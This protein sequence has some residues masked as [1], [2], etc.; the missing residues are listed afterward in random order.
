MREIVKSFRV[1]R[2]IMKFLGQKRNF[3]INV[4][5]TEKLCPEEQIKETYFSKE[6]SFLFFQDSQSVFSIPAETLAKVVETVT[7]VA[8][9]DFE[10]KIFETLH[11]ISTLAKVSKLFLLCAK[12]RTFS[13]KVFFRFVKTAVSA[14]RKNFSGCLSG[15]FFFKSFFGV[16]ATIFSSLGKETIQVCQKIN[17]RVQKEKSWKLTL[18]SCSFYS[19]STKSRQTLN[20]GGKLCARCLKL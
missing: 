20:F 10:G 17:L 16:W 8:L 14:C 11:N 18:K 4:A 12:I 13:R 15:T 1:S 7:F 3:F 19:F 6:K 9:E 5:K 2:W